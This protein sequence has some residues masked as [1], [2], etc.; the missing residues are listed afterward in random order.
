MPLDL[1]K[2]IVFVDV[3]YLVFYRF[4]ALK[5]WFKFAY[6]DIDTTAEDYKWLE[7]TVF[8]EKYQ[9]TLLD[10]VTKI[11][12]QKKVP[13]GNI[14]FCYDCHFKDNWRLKYC[15][16]KAVEECIAYKG[17][18]KSMLKKQGFSDYKVFDLVESTYL[19]EFSNTHGNLILKHKNAEADDCIA[20]A[21]KELINK[22]NYTK[23]IWIV[24]SDYDYVQLCNQQIHL[25]D[26]K[27]KQLDEIQLADNNL[28]NVEYLIRKIMIGDKSDNISPSQFNPD[29]VAEVNQ[30]CGT[31]LRKNK[32]G[33]YNVTEATFNKIKECP[34]VW[35]PLVTYFN[36]NKTVLKSS[37][38]KPTNNVEICLIGSVFDLNQRL[39]DFD[40][41][42][43]KIK[44]KIC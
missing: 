12:K 21:I 7:N 8:M 38:A 44:V 16:P 31:K 3:S 1:E 20:L 14:V 35:N 43:S 37:K 36:T 29:K 27:R 25:I 22:K 39:I 13:F 32:E 15:K 17:D 9:K 11:A 26:L 40:L 10:T 28:N 34:D 5:K 24:A 2:N 23:T 6:K 41:I 42:P 33:V 18:R 30:L 19:P 4:F